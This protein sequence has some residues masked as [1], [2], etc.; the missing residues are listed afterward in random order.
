MKNGYAEYEEFCKNQIKQT[1]F[2]QHRTYKN[3]KE[4]YIVIQ[5][6]I[7]RSAGKGHLNIFRIV[8]RKRYLDVQLTSNM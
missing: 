3:A 4:I 1:F 5:K 2:Y 7:F 6:K 8:F